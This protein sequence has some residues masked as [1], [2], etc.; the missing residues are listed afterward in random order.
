[1]SL[2]DTDETRNNQI[3]HYKE[4]LKGIIAATRCHSCGNNIPVAL[5]GYCGKYCNKYCW[6]DVYYDTL[7][8][9]SFDDC[10]YCNNDIRF[11]LANSKYHSVWKSLSNTSG[12]YWPMC[13]PIII[14]N[15]KCIQN[16]KPI[17]I[18]NYNN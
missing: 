11:S 1:M 18:K 15:N 9:C 12:Y 5:L 3:L 16:N 6:K 7:K 8:E 10:E 13:N 17:F 2:Q 4:A 14:C